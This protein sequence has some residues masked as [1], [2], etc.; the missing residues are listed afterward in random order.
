MLFIP[1]GIAYGEKG[2]D[3]IDPNMAPNIEAEPLAKKLILQKLIIPSM[4]RRKDHE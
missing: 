1:P 4:E 2:G 3:N